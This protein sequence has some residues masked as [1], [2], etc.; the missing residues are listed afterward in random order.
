[1]TCGD[2]NG[3]VEA[4]LVA[5]AC[6]SCLPLSLASN[7]AY[8]CLL[9]ADV[10]WQDQILCVLGCDPYQHVPGTSV[11]ASQE[12]HT[13]Q[14]G[15]LIEDIGEFGKPADLRRDAAA[16]AAKLQDVI[17]QYGGAQYRSLQQQ[18]MGRD[19]C[20]DLP[21]QE[22]EQVTINHFM[23]TLSLHVPAVKFC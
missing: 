19:A 2:C 4:R 16:L 1:M 3:V 6:C 14:V 21:A 9:P 15:Y 8:H 12:G 17:G 10:V 7:Q 23:M 5:S 20:W 11:Y 13:A 22:W 18:G